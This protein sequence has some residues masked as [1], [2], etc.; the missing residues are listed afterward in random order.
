MQDADGAPR[1][2]S[3]G[4][5]TVRCDQLAVQPLGEGH[6]TGVA[7]AD[8]GA[9]FEG[10]PHQ[11]QRWDTLEPQLLQMPDG[12]LETLVAQR[13]RQPALAQHRHGLDVDQ[14]GRSDLIGGAQLTAGGLPSRLVVGEGVGQDGGVDDDHRALT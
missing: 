3:G 7:G 4:E 5:A 8:V 6:V 13:A 2:M 14:I 10:A 12:S 9:Q 1:A 11:S